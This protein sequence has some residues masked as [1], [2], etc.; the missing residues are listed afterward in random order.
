MAPR[1]T[2]FTRA[3]VIEYGLKITE[4]EGAVVKSVQCRFCIVFGKEEIPG[5]KRQRMQTSRVNIGLPHFVRSITKS[6]HESQHSQRWEEYQTLSAEK[7]QNYFSTK[8]A[9]F[10]ES[11]PAYFG[12]SD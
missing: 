9:S 5:K 2:P 10:I 8:T 12:K 11:M 6:H 1:S 7:K 4:Q 3:H